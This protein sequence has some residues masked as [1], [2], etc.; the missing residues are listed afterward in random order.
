MLSMKKIDL[1]RKYKFDLDMPVRVI[2]YK[3]DVSP[4]SVYKY[5][6]LDDFS[7]TLKK[8]RKKRPSKIAPYEPIIK[9]WLIEDKNRHYKQRHTAKRVYDRLNEIFEN[10]DVSYSTLANAFQKIKS[11]VYYVS[12]E[13]APL[14]HIPGEAQ[15]DLGN[16]TFTENSV[17]YNGYYLVMSFPYSNIAFC[18][19]L[20]GKNI[21]CILQAM[22]NIFE[23]I[24]GVP[25]E[26]TFDNDSA[27]VRCFGERVSKRVENDL[28]LRF[29]NHYDFRAEYCPAN[30]P[31]QKGHVEGKIGYLRRNLF[32]PMPV[33]NN[34]D[35]YNKEL[36]MRCMILH[37]HKHHRSKES[38]IELFNCDVQALLLMPQKDFE[39]ATILERKVDR[40]GCV[41]FQGQRIYYL[42]PCFAKS[43]VQ[44]KLTYNKVEF[45]EMNQKPIAEFER[46]YGD[47]NYTA[48]HWEQ[49]LPTI[50]RK[51]NSLFHSAFTDMF[52]ERLKAFLFNGTAKLRG[53]Y[54][55][56][57]CELIKNISLERALR[58][59]DE[60]A[61][62]CFEN[63][64]EILS[65][66]T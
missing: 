44:V 15:V 39:V 51:P 60:A 62:K 66:A 2:S 59:A 52:T 27:L 9:E 24:G 28:F 17:K 6:K 21:Q 61:E 5:I 42:E 50:A 40:E 43:K 30:S 58:I 56:A 25:H 11:E 20:K 19:I 3:L 31:N 36:L 16:C 63:I 48:I 29:K 4:T 26:I 55:K 65:L 35:D 12:K 37:N 22:K 38:I 45:Y 14:R 1:I 41:R 33:M 49:W 32:V 47:K 34:I 13:Y 23:F 46:L 53:I 18:Q 54:M 7:Q 10:F 64:D 57:L 8:P